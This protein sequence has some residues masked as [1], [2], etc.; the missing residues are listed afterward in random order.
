MSERP[1]S[2][3][4][5]VV[6]LARPQDALRDAITAATRLP[7]AHA[8]AALLD[9]ATLDP[10]A[11]ER[12]R[13]LATRLST[14]VRAAKRDAAGAE[15]MVQAYSLS[16][17]EGIALMCLAEALL[18]IP[19]AQTADAL[20]RDKLAQG[21]WRSHASLTDSLFVNAASWGLVITGRIIAPAADT[22]A[23]GRA[24]GDSLARLGEPVIRAAMRAAMRFLGEQFVLGE[25]I[26]KA[27]ERARL[28]EAQ[29]FRYS[30]DML[31]EAALTAEDAAR[32]QSAYVE[33]MH[34]IGAASAGRGV[35]AGP[36][37]SV[38]LSAL[39]PR[40]SRS[41]RERVLA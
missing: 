7:E 30:Y 2:P 12:T 9:A 31:G 1:P 38:K 32:Y 17:E 19:D 35:A 10:A 13:E 5:A 16:S 27:M 26:P 11:T 24:L 4:P 28:R 41:Q 29:G 6:P 25:T 8:V 15:A 39:H 33:A 20:I 18:R 3:R 40:Y 14:Q 37:L 21:D 36:G 34:A 23:L 22:G